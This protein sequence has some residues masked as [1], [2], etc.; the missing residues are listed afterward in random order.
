MGQPLRV[1]QRLSGLLEDA[2]LTQS[3]TP[4]RMRSGHL[5]RL[6]T[7]M[8]IHDTPVGQLTAQVAQGQTEYREALARCNALTPRHA[9]DSRWLQHRDV[10]TAPGTQVR[11]LTEV[12]EN[13]YRQLAHFLDVYH[14]PH[15][16]APTRREAMRAAYK[17]MAAFAA[18]GIVDRTILSVAEPIV[19]SLPHGL[20][21]NGPIPTTLSRT[22]GS[23]PLFRPSHIAHL[24]T[25]LAHTRRAR[26]P[27]DYRETSVEDIKRALPE[28]LTPWHTSATPSSI[29]TH[30]LAFTAPHLTVTHPSAASHERSVA[31][32]LN[33]LFSTATWNTLLGAGAAPNILG[34]HVTLHD[35]PA[36]I[37]L[38]AQPHRV[39][40]QL[41]NHGVRLTAA[42][43]PLNAYYL[44]LTA[45]DQP[46]RPDRGPHINV[47]QRPL[48]SNGYA[49]LVIAPKETHLPTESQWRTAFIASTRLFVDIDLA[50]GEVGP[51]FGAHI[52][53]RMAPWVIGAAAEHML[54]RLHT[55][56]KLNRGYTARST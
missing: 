39:E 35:T 55:A 18:S 8:G 16:D 9:A 10:N 4:I 43:Y 30:H 56:F 3:F 17:V 23:T 54:D 46:E 38:R 22:H 25:F 47:L 7:A 52:F 32:V 15:I 37:P 26:R 42:V 28:D 34:A 1:Q 6:G 11:D 51:A 49:P 45:L 14:A 12:Q 41:S 24:D 21:E 36:V 5:H 40:F 2:G 27:I 50:A 53:D 31:H 33:G 44:S 29:T 13:A 48:Q 20:I 19:W